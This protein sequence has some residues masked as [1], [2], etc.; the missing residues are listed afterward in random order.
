MYVLILKRLIPATRFVLCHRNEHEAFSKSQI[1]VRDFCWRTSP[2][3]EHPVC[4]FKTKSD[5]QSFVAEHGNHIP[6]HMIIIQEDEYKHS[7]GI[8]F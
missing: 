4:A 8:E 7:K 3:P 1:G 5:A 6:A 2:N